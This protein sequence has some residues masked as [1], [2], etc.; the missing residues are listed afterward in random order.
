VLSCRNSEGASPLTQ[1]AREIAVRTARSGDTYR[2]YGFAQAVTI[3]RRGLA[4][5]SQVPR[6]SKIV[7]YG[8]RHVQNPVHR[9]VI[10][11]FVMLANPNDP[12]TTSVKRTA[13][14]HRRFSE[15]T[16][17][18]CFFATI[19]VTMRETM[20]SRSIAPKELH[21]FRRKSKKLTQDPK[22][23]YVKPFTATPNM[24]NE[25][26]SLN[27]TCAAHA[28]G[29]SIREGVRST[30]LRV[31]SGKR[32]ET[33]KGFLSS[34]MIKFSGFFPHS[35]LIKFSGFFPHSPLIKFSGFFPLYH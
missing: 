20:D 7:L 35:P 33:R 5:Q 24:A 19:A 15:A 14:T 4:C 16:F 26:R 11:R 29:T 18:G 34:A 25:G 3:S 30:V 32:S 13:A 8:Q 10:G 9:S 22:T 17:L 28:S 23:V 12:Q 2:I 1:L 6:A 31:S 27:F 21:T